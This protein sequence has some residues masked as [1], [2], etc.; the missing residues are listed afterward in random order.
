VRPA[1]IRRRRRFAGIEVE[2]E[3]FGMAGADPG[4]GKRGTT[5]GVDR[6]LDPIRWM[7]EDQWPEA[8]EVEEKVS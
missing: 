2:D 6:V 4:N 1:P 5:P 7:T 8:V 3:G